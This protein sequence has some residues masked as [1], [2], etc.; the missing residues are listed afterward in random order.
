MSSACYVY[1]IVRQN[2]SLTFAGIDAGA[3]LAMVTWRNL[4]A[5]IERTDGDG[6][7][8]TISALLHHEAVVEAVRGR[9]PA[10]PVRFGTV[11]RDETSLACALAERYE[12]ITADLDR[13]GDKVEVSL[14]A[15]WTESESAGERSAR[16]R[17]EGA[18]PSPSAGARYLHARAAQVGR[19]DVLQERARVVA[20]MLAAALGPRALDQR[21]SLVPTP[22]IALR[23][24]YLLNTS[25]VGAF[26]AAFD[27]TCLA[28]R[29]PR[30]VLTGPRSPYSFVRRA[31]MD[32]A[33][34]T[35]ARVAELV[36]ILTDPA[37]LLSRCGAR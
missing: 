32:W 13:L 22:K 2:A 7:S 28:W 15:L 14:T 33:P 1:A 18:R 17:E 34:P 8:I 5:V 9:G 31:E 24:A 19:A 26:R 4:S 36:P 3:E 25:D 30:L 29:D 23:V 35:D 20:E 16:P 21:Q 27:A 11:F 37:A 6:P 12:A 10:L